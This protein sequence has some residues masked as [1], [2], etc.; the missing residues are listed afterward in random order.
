MTEIGSPCGFFYSSKTHYKIIGREDLIH[1]LSPWSHCHEAPA[2]FLK[3][4][5]SCR[6]SYL[7]YKA[8]LTGNVTIVTVSKLG[9]NTMLTPS[10]HST[11]WILKLVCFKLR[12]QSRP[13]PWM[14]GLQ[15]DDSQMFVGYS[16]SA[17]EK[18]LGYLG[19]HSSINWTP[20]RWW[21]HCPLNGQPHSVLYIDLCKVLALSLWVYYI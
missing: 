4:W 9:N 8:L 19:Q 17:W 1:S 6:S 7:I 11:V 14:L 3:L 21:L 12:P 13:C 20:S 18:V 15:N 2:L 10:L 16:N 5:K